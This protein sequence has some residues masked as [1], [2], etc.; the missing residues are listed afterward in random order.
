MGRTSAKV[1]NR[2]QQ[3]NYDRITIL[4]KKGDKERI[5]R[6]AE[7]H[8]QSV[9]SFITELIQ[10]KMNEEQHAEPEDQVNSTE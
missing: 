4:V 7:E 5:K 9:N 1:T 3:K 10:R 6:Y 8:G 2:Y